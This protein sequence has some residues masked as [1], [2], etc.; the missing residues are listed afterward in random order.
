MLIFLMGVVAGCLTLLT[1][2]RFVTVGTLRIVIDDFEKR[3]YLFLKVS[4]N[5]YQI[6]AKRYIVLKVDYQKYHSQ[7]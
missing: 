6:I 3:P 5:I 1:V 2:S 4:K 7:E